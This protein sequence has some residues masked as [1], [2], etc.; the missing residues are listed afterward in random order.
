MIEP[1]RQILFALA[2]AVLLLPVGLLA[3]ENDPPPFTVRLTTGESIP[4]VELKPSGIDVVHIVT[5][6]GNER[7]IP[8]YR[9]QS[10]RDASGL[11]RTREVVE[12]GRSLGGSKGAPPGKNPHSALCWR[13][14]P[15]CGSFMVTEAGLLYRVDDYPFPG[16]DT[17]LAAVFE[18][19]Y[20]KNISPKEAVGAT[21]YA[22]VS[23]LTRLG[24]CPRYR[25]WLSHSTSVDLS[26]GVLL[27]GED[28]AIDYDPPGFL[29][30]ASYNMKDLLALTLE[31]EYSRYR[32]YG[33]GL[34]SQYQTT[35]DWTFRGGAKLGSGLGLLGGAIFVGLGIAV[36]AAMAGG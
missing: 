30:G 22:L 36:A 32:D 27:G 3:A 21:G 18:V 26:A 6:D 4:A 16:M 7:D 10:V 20:M 12:L 29:L 13:G 33:D 34:S 19:G 11:D 14:K 28:P 8:T 9:I 24:I 31:S 17:N 5:P 1:S 15:E 35:S 23:D 2:L 25:R